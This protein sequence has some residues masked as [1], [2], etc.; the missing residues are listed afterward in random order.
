MTTRVGERTTQRYRIQDIA[1]DF[2]LADVRE[3]P[4]T[5]KEG[6]F[7]DL[8]RLLRHAS[9]Q[10]SGDDLSKSKSRLASWIFRVR[11]WLGRV[12]GWDRVFNELPIPGCTETS[13]RDRIA[14]S[15]RAEVYTQST[16]LFPLRPV[17]RDQRDAAMELS[18]R[19]V[20]VVMHYA[21]VPE[22]DLFRAHMA[23]YVKTRGWLGRVYVAATAPVRKYIVYPLI[24]K[25]LAKQWRTRRMVNN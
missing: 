4:I 3:M 5:G 9:G 10:P 7:H 21:W 11:C 15:D 22:G 23:L 16:S 13:L 14:P 6:E 24:M 1:K 17:Y 18:N 19:T 25:Q 20:H 12:F 2:H 8:L